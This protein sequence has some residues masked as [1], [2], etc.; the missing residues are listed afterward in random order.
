MNKGIF[1]PVTEDNTFAVDKFTGNTIVVYPTGISKYN[2]DVIHYAVQAF[3]F[4]VK[5]GKVRTFKQLAEIISKN[6]NMGNHEIAETVR[7]LNLQ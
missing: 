4:L 5:D 3:K 2:H 1:E 7:V 6:Y